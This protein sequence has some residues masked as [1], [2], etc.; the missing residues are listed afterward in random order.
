MNIYTVY[1]S[2]AEVYMQPFIATNDAVAQR[3]FQDAVNADGHH[4]NKFPG[5]FS[6]FG[7]GTFSEVTG[8]VTA[9]KAFTN[10]GLATQFIESPPIFSLPAEHVQAGSA[11]AEGQKP[12]HALP[13]HQRPQFAGDPPADRGSASIQVSPSASAGRE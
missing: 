7:I 9:A 3:I 4:F 8:Q 2:K 10:L 11:P 1:D 5:D 6:L 13:W 12:S